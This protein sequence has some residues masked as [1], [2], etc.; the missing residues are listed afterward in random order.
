MH[1]SRVL[2]C[3]QYLIHSGSSGGEPLQGGA[4]DGGERVENQGWE[5]GKKGG[6]AGRKGMERK[7]EV[8]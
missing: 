6:A 2:V 3:F 4:Q 1:V 5:H 7:C 8:V